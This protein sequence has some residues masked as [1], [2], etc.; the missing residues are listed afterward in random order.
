MADDVSLLA[1]SVDSSNAV[2]GLNSVTR[3]TGSMLDV[4][5]QAMPALAGLFSAGAIAKAA[6]SFID[7]ASDAQEALGVLDDVFGRNEALLRRAGDAIEELADRYAYSTAGASQQISMTADTFHKFGVELA[8]SLDLSVEINKLGADLAAFTN[9]AGGSEGATK[10]LTK[11]LLG[12]REMAKTL[13]IVISEELVKAQM[14]KDAKEGITYASQ[15]QA[16]MMATLAVMQK[17]S[18]AA[19]GK[20]VKEADNYARRMANLGAKFTDLKAA[21]GETLIDPFT[22]IIESVTSCVDWLKGLDDGWRSTIVWSGIAVGA[23]GALA[24]AYAALKLVWIGLTATRQTG[25]A[26]QAQSVAGIEAEVAANATATGAVAAHTEAV[27]ADTLALEANTAAQAGNNAARAGSSAAT[28]G[29]TAA[30]GAGSGAA[31]AGGGLLGGLGVMGTAAVAA[32]GAGL[33]NN[34]IESYRKGIDRG[35]E[36]SQAAMEGLFNAVTAGAV[37]AFRNVQDSW[38]KFQKGQQDAFDTAI[39]VME[40]A[41]DV[42]TLGVSKLVRNLTEGMW[43]GIMGWAVKFD[44]KGLI[45]TV[46]SVAVPLIGP[47]VAEKLGMTPHLGLSE[48]GAKSAELDEQQKKNA[49]EDRIKQANI[50]ADKALEEGPRNYTDSDAWKKFQEEQTRSQ[51]VALTEG[52]DRAVAERENAQKELEKKQTQYQ[53]RMEGLDAAQ[54]AL[55]SATDELAASRAKVKELEANGSSPEIEQAKRDVADK[56]N[57]YMTAQHAVDN[58]DAT[59][60]QQAAE[61]VTEAQNKLAELDRRVAE[62]RADD[63]EKELKERRSREDSALDRQY[64]GIGTDEGRAGESRARYEQLQA[65][66]DEMQNAADRIKA[67]EE[68]LKSVDPLSDEAKELREN[69]TIQKAIA[70]ELD[71]RLELET[72]I[73]QKQREESEAL[74][75][76]AK[77]E[78]EVNRQREQRNRDLADR[79]SKMAEDYAAKWMT[80]REKVA[81]NRGKLASA[82]RE[83]ETFEYRQSRINDM[84]EQIAALGETAKQG[85]EEG[86][87]AEEEMNRLVE[88][89]ARAEEELARD[90]SKNLDEQY[91]ALNAIDEVAGSKAQEAADR[92]RKEMDKHSDMEKRDRKT[93]TVQK[94]VDAASAEGFAQM[95]KVY[96]TSQKKIEDHT[97]NIREYTRQMKQ[98][99]MQLAARGDTS[100]AVDVEGA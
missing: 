38:A 91:A 62:S 26:V 15:Q 55:K 2:R 59:G 77:R 97:K 18:A 65:R 100:W 3:A 92:Y 93:A 11:A 37:P 94:A 20:A 75:S 9:Y 31:A 60:L 33:A 72:R 19:Q 21:F 58:Y 50:L 68:Q 39:T 28:A 90:R 57:A 83:S 73:V 70:G 41:G 66:L 63:A 89:R 36:K 56:Y 4:I 86:R 42:L 79:A 69:I 34:F 98:Y 46:I 87:K 84:D 53:S 54:N 52:T 22:K 35:K 80:D 40:Q 82:I 12:E 48:E 27:A 8:Q 45:G 16:K 17:Q 1:L 23:A 71:D 88:E 5:R 14:E 96:D 99:L 95:A 49:E 10:A 43:D 13:G 51:R 74:R 78:E 67:M 32:V 24:S 85:G 44:W 47:A 76:V 25:N 64:A 81:M 30:R 29:A 6:G 7:A 61:A